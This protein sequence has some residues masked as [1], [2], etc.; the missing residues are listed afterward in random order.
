MPV[1]RHPAGAPQM[2]NHRALGKR[3]SDTLDAPATV[4]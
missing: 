2:A 1:L 3:P 4:G